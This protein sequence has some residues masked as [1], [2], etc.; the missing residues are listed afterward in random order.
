VMNL[1]EQLFGLS[2]KI[3]LV[4][5]AG[6]GLG[7][8]VAEGFAEVGAHVICAD[9]EQSRV[10]E[11]VKAISVAGGAASPLRID[12][13]NEASVAAA[14]GTVA[15]TPLDILVNFAGVA[16]APA[17]THELDIAEWHRLISINLTGTFLT[18]RAALPKM[19]EQG[20]SIINVASVIGL[21]GYYP[22]FPSTGLHYAAS[23]A[24][25]VGLTRQL[26]VE[27][28][29]QNVRANVIAPG[30]HFGTR[31]G[32]FRRQQSTEHEQERF[33]AEIMRRIPMKRTGQPSEILGLA[34]Y[35]AAPA[36]AYLTGQLIAQDGGWTAC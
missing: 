11:V 27:Y 35:L 33:M 25:I 18:T 21:G 10:D 8:V 28:A 4:T 31:L 32:D 15:Q 5:G 29:A 16:A 14:F 36:S 24:G 22:D 13:A 17:R 26:A 12:V 34:L 30:W 3:A 7:R 1:L 2:G 6:S 20:G 19:L 23:K 9:I